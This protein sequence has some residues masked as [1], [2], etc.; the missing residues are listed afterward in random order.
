MRGISGFGEN[1]QRG[2]TGDLPEKTA[3]ERRRWLEHGRGG[4][5]GGDVEGEAEK[6]GEVMLEENPAVAWSVRPTS[7]VQ[8]KRPN[9][10]SLCSHAAHLVHLGSSLSLSLSLSYFYV[11]P[12]MDYL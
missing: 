12:F 10:D 3:E 1:A 9:E 6:E 4:V 7:A 8:Q 5:R 2:L 11:S